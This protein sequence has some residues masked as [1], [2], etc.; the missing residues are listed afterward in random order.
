[1]NPPTPDAAEWLTYY[2]EAW[3][4]P[5]IKWSKKQKDQWCEYLAILTLYEKNF[6][7][8]DSPLPPAPTMKEG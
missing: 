6:H 5:K 8:D 7:F 4:G 1:M 3:N 2:L